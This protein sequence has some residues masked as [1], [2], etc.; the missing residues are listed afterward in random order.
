MGKSGAPFQ[1]GQVP[2][3]GFF[4][5]IFT[6]D[7]VVPT[8]QRHKVIPYFSMAIN[9]L[10]QLTIPVIAIHLELVGFHYG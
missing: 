9:R 8:T 3:Q 6:I 10:M 2:H 4:A 5:R 7:S 1:L